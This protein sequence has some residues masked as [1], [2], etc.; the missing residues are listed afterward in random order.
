MCGSHVLGI[1]IGDLLEYLPQYVR[2]V[3]LVITNIPLLWMNYRRAVG[4]AL[5]GLGAAPPRRPG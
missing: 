2:K 5:S 3:I 1:I 4:D